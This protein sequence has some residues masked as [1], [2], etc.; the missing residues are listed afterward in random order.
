MVKV[1]SRRDFISSL[2]NL[3]EINRNESYSD[4]VREQVFFNFIDEYAPEERYMFKVRDMNTGK[5]IIKVEEDS[6]FQFASVSE[7]EFVNMEEEYKYLSENELQFTDNGSYK[8]T[9]VGKW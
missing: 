7:K 6:E 1:L 3:V 5:Y 4:R 9:S 2:K 8:T